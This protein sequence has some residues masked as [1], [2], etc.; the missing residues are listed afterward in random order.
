M[1][2]STVPFLPPSR[3]VTF[4]IA[5]DRSVPAQPAEC[6]D[7][8]AAGEADRDRQPALVAG[9]AQGSQ[10]PAASGAF[11]GAV[12][13][14]HEG[15]AFWVGEW[16]GFLRRDGSRQPLDLPYSYVIHASE[17]KKGVE[18]PHAHVIVPAM[19]RDRERPFNVYPKDTQHTREVAQRETECIFG[20]ERLRDRVFEHHVGPDPER[21]HEPQPQRDWQPSFP[22]RELDRD[23][24]GRC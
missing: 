23:F 11:S 22:G 7:H 19:D 9:R 14:E 17:D 2:C 5:G 16:A 12:Q 3:K 1:V 18:S 15:Q 10:V 24:H 13:A 20:L 8:A 21:E 6:V 4:G